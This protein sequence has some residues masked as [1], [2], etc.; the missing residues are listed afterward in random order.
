[1]AELSRAVAALRIV[2]DDLLP[3]DVTNLLGVPPTRSF[4]RGDEVRH[5]RGPIRVARFGLWILDAPETRPAD[6]DTQVSELLGPL[7]SDLG[8]WHEMAARF[9]VD[10]FCGW[11]MKL[12][13]EGLAIAPG[14]L[15]ALAE[16]QIVLDLDIYAGDSDLTPD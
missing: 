3:D 14:T 7:T 10:L 15:K 9:S 6:V 12:G 16:R 1:M 13:N 2:G 11:F 8:T 5:R 4:A